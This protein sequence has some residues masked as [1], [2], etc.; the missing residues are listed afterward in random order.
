MQQPSA[1][2]ATA[3]ALEFQPFF[4]VA[5]ARLVGGPLAFGIGLLKI[6]LGK[7]LD[8]LDSC[9]HLAVGYA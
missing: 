2:N 1:H 4:L 9:S 8:F 7:C 3:V 6:A 5:L